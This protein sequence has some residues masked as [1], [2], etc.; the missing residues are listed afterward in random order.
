MKRHAFLVATAIVL[1]LM[2]GLEAGP[3]AGSSRNTMAQAPR[4]SLFFGLD[5]APWLPKTKD[6]PSGEDVEE[7]AQKL[8]SRIRNVDPFGVATFPREDA[9]PLLGE[10]ASRPTPR[11]T[12]N[13]AL[14]TLKIN[15]VNLIEKWV[16]IGGRNVVEGDV[17]ELSFREEI[18][19]ALVVEVGAKEILFNDLERDETGVMPHSVIQQLEMEPLRQFIPLES[20][21]LPMEPVS[22]P[23]K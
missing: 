16:L 10:D 5:T 12:L 3:P 9:D 7:M 8:S 21:M 13:Q 23:T 6:L 17:I 4:D 15:G 14:Q 18:F 11:V 22:A 20:K 2:T 1:A 19:K